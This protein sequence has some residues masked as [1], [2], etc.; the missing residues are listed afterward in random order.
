[1]GPGGETAGPVRREREGV[2]GQEALLQFL[3]EAGWADFVGLFGLSSSSSSGAQ[4][5]P[6]VPGTRPA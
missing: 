4:G 3:Q 1:M 2:L 6:R 5:P